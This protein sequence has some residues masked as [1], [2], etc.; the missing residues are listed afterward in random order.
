MSTLLR[1]GTPAGVLRRS[2]ATGLLRGS[3]WVALLGV[4]IAPMG[5]VVSLA[6]GANHLPQLLAAGLVGATVNSVVSAACSAALAVGIATA[7]ALLIERS[8]LPGRGGAR[9]LVLT[10]LLIP[11]FVGA[12]AW[13]GLLT[14]GGLIDQLLGVAPW[15]F[16]GG[17]GV[18]FLLTV[19]SV[20][21]AYLVISAALARV[22][23]DLE[24]AARIAGA[25]PTRVFADVTLPVIR[26]GLI[27]AFTL[28]FIGN[29]G[30]FGIPVLVGTP[31]GYDTLATMVYRFLQSGTVSAPLQVTSQIGLVLLVMAIAGI[32]ADRLLAGRAVETDGSGSVGS[33]LPLGAL[34]TPAAIVVWVVAL[35]VTVGPLLALLA[36]ALL[37]APGVALTFANLT[38]ANLQ[39]AL[40]APNTIQGLTNSVLLALGAAVLCGLLGLS[41]GL[42]TT[43]TPA[44]GDG[45]M[46][47]LALLPQAIPGLII[48]VG[49]LIL[50]RYTDL[51]NT[52]WVILGAYVTAF[53]ALVV[54]AVRG[55]L[56]GMNSSWEEAARISGA[57]PVRALTD[58]SAR[59]AIP[60]AI[61]G[62]ALVAVTAVRELTL[63]V[64]LVAPGTQTLGVVIFG[65]QQ[66]GDYNAS[67]ALSLVF[68]IVGVAAVALVVP[69]AGGRIRRRPTAGETL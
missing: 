49:W 12:I 54:Q 33:T 58:T 50:G 17:G 45:A 46:V 32:A 34:R 20:P 39:R 15:Q 44:R 55:P 65:Y 13:T 38:L 19:Y 24:V 67:S 21:V 42:L 5:L 62:A 22:P 63:S 64:L 53:T 36:R 14:R 68:M 2:P 30:D 48:A 6:L 11:P 66:A 52:L 60:A 1:G 9:L 56:A 28:V 51:Y 23:E 26:P 10:P 35:A 18:I 8:D 59:L 47:F 4:V 7:A 61:A 43:R 29:L 69:G 37:P 16:Y 27:A 3:V 25:D 57:G 41:I 40:T 31:G